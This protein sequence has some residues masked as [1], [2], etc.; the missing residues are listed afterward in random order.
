MDGPWIWT[1]AWGIL[2]LVTL[3]AAFGSDRQLLGVVGIDVYID[4]LGNIAQLV[5]DALESQTNQGNIQPAIVTLNNLNCSLANASY[6]IAADKRCGPNTI[7]PT[8][9]G[10][11]N[12]IDSIDSFES[13]VCSCSTCNAQ[14][15]GEHIHVGEIIGGSITGFIALVVVVLMLTFK[16]SCQKFG[17]WVIAVCYYYN[18]GPQDLPEPRPIIPIFNDTPHDMQLDPVSN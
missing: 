5:R 9:G 10:I 4:E 2:W 1:N 11:C 15:Y 6:P 14:D 3:K 13:I 7:A 18:Q 17:D 12:Q 8:N 16:C